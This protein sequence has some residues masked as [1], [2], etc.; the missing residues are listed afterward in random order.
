MPFGHA[1]PPPGRGTGLVLQNA[2]VGRTEVGQQ[3]ATA[4]RRCR[5]SLHYQRCSIWFARC[6]GPHLHGDGV[7]HE[8]GAQLAMPFGRRLKTAGSGGFWGNWRATF[9]MS[10]KKPCPA[11]GRLRP[12]HQGVEASGSR[13]PRSGGIHHPA[14]VY[15]PRC[16]HRAPGWQFARAKGHAARQCDDLDVVFGPRQR[17]IS[18]HLVGQ[19][20][21]RALHQRLHGKAAGLSCTPAGGETEGGGLT[22]AGLTWAMMSLPNSARRQGRRNLDGRHGRV[23]RGGGLASVAGAGEGAE[24]SGGGEAV[25]VMPDYRR[26][27][28]SAGLRFVGLGGV[29]PLFAPVQGAYR[30]P[31]LRGLSERFLPRPCLCVCACTGLRGS[32]AACA[33]TRG[34]EPCRDDG[35]GLGRVGAD[36]RSA[37][38]GV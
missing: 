20:A 29:A 2:S 33:P 17:R 21:R 26:A 32:I 31:H 24:I 35:R 27:A 19:L 12:A 5:P 25:E 13:L 1:A 4:R 18:G 10:S 3:Q 28:A 14:L 30:P 38:A 11:C 23:P 22:A 34:G 6:A 15:P 7:A 9:T 36:L 8:L 16:V 37:S